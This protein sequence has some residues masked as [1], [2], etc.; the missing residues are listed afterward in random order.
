[1]NTWDM[2]ESGGWEAWPWAEKTPG[3]CWSGGSLPIL[4][5]HTPWVPTCQ[6]GK[7]LP[8]GHTLCLTRI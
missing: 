8:I 5:S 7:A 3:T 6:F 1:M 2:M 4:H